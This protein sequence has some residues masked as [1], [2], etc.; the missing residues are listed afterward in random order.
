MRKWIVF[1]DSRGQELAAYTKAE[2]FE[3]EWESTKAL[4]AFEHGIQPEEI[5]AKE[6]ER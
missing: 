4:L 6:V 1:Y 5:T 3:G 2:T